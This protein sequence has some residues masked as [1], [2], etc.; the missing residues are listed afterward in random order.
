MAKDM[1]R[2]PIN[3]KW[4]IYFV[5]AAF[6]FMLYCLEHEAISDEASSLLLCRNSTQLYTENKCK[7][8]A[9]K[10]AWERLFFF[11]KMFKL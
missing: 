9:P 11:D 2:M 6:G 10:E 7:C 1:I 4:G 3:D 5:D 8:N